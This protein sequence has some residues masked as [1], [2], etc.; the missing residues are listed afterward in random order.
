MTHLLADRLDELRDGV[1]ARLQDEVVR[2][3]VAEFFD[4]EAALEARDAVEAMFRLVFL[5][6]APEIV[7]LDSPLAGV[8]HRL[9]M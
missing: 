2:R 1:A 6:D 4:A 5:D 7:A 9:Y 8:A 3:R